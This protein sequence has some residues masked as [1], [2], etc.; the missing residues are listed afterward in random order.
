[1]ELWEIK[2]FDS[3][4]NTDVRYMGMGFESEEFANKELDTIKRNDE[5]WLK[6][7]GKPRWPNRSNYR[8]EKIDLVIRK[9]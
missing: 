2:Y 7:H 6:L 9:R 3:D 5:R 4:W 8:V 1:M